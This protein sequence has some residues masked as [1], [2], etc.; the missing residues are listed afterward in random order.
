MYS[1]A[2]WRNFLPSAEP[3]ISLSLLQF[4]VMAA[5]AAMVFSRSPILFLLAS[6]CCSW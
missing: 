6:F 2:I 1:C 5:C 4:S 3:M